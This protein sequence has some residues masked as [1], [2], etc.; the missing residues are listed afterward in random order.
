VEAEVPR[1]LGESVSSL[2]E[3]AQRLERVI[4]SV[5]ARQL[6]ETHNVPVLKPASDA[7]SHSPDEI[8]SKN[9]MTVGIG[10][11]PRGATASPTAFRLPEPPRGT[12]TLQP[13]LVHSGTRP[14][15]SVTIGDALAKPVRRRSWLSRLVLGS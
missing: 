10:P 7:F 5:K 1:K 15:K 12:T 3:G 6:A 13:P 11:A 4:H 9:Y 8:W 2:S 14:A